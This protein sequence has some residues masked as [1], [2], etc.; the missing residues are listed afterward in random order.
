MA[1]EFPSNN[2]PNTLDLKLVAP[3]SGLATCEVDV[4]NGSHPL[5]THTC[6]HLAISFSVRN[7]K[8][9]NSSAEL[10]IDC[11]ELLTDNSTWGPWKSHCNSISVGY[12]SSVQ[13]RNIDVPPLKVTPHAGQIQIRG[14]LKLGQTVC[15]VGLI[16]SK[17]ELQADTVVYKGTYFH[18]NTGRRSKEYSMSVLPNSNAN[19]GC[20]YRVNNVVKTIGCNLKV[21]PEWHD[22]GNPSDPTL[23]ITVMVPG[24][25]AKGTVEWEIT[26]REFKKH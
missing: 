20:G 23:T 8:T 2:D 10:K 5:Q 22:H 24:N 4:C 26:C 13:Y 11:R 15:S 18:I 16:V 21:P 9:P 12:D 3:V 7:R 14:Q 1:N 25:G 6:R 17:R 19:L